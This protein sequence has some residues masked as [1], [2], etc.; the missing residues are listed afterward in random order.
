[1]LDEL[2]CF[3]SCPE[4]DIQYII[5]SGIF[6]LCFSAKFAPK[7][8][9][10]SAVF[11]ANLSPK[12][13]RNLTFFPANYQ[14]PCIGGEGGEEEITVVELRRKKQEVSGFLA[15]RVRLSLHIKGGGG[16]GVGGKSNCGRIKKGEMVSTGFCTVRVWFSQGESVGQS[17]PLFRVI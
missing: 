12:I 3:L 9:A 1:M 6:L 14:K 5:F 16:A 15:V 17:R 10:K 13:P 4:F 7:I 2:L 11:S 8:P